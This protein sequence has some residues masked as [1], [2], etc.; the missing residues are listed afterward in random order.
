MLPRPGQQVPA[1]LHTGDVSKEFA[2]ALRQ[3]NSTAAA[4]ELRRYFDRLSS[5]AT[6]SSPAAGDNFKRLALPDE[7][8]FSQPQPD[9]K[10]GTQ[11]DSCENLEALLEASS[12]AA[13]SAQVARSVYNDARPSAGPGALV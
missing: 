3:L 13:E 2:L 12:R 9:R 4:S 8:A 7:E 11:H 1:N 6:S 10:M 5:Q